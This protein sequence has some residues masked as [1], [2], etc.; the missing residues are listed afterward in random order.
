M[1][2]VLASVLPAASRRA[3]SQDLLRESLR[4]R[5]IGDDWIYDDWKK[6]KERAV[7]QKKP[8]FVVFRCVP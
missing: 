6:A 3:V 4:D 7:A 8:I 1:L 5:G 2:F